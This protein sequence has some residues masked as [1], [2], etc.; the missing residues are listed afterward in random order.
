MNN[1]KQIKTKA[2]TA[3]AAIFGILLSV[4]NTQAVP[5][6]YTFNG[7]TTLVSGDSATI[8][9]LGLTIGTAVSYTV[10][11]DTD[12]DG[13]YTYGS[14]EITPLDTATRDYFYAD[15]IGGDVLPDVTAPAGEN[16]YATYGSTYG[17]ASI[18]V[19]SGLYINSLTGTSHPNLWTTTGADFTF[20]DQWGDAM[21]STYGLVSGTLT[22]DAISTIN[23]FTASV[24]EAASLYLLV[25]GLLGM[26]FTCRRKTR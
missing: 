10:M 9:D 8:S 24:P 4:G 26:G 15:Y 1:A 14:V 3:L 16:N 20:N 12:L 11:I 7:T 2:Y 19:N 13:T 22:L 6:Y 5:M 17:R 18:V 25:I 23:P 21:N